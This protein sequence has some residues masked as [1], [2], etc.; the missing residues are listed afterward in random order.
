MAE[1]HEIIINVKDFSTSPG[2]R[3]VIQGE[4]SGELFYHTVLNPQ[5]VTAIE[6][7]KSIIVNLDGV[8][9]YMSSFLDEAFGNL[10]FDFGKEE[11][12][13]RLSF[14][15]EE[16]PEWK[17][18]IIKETYLDW[19]NRR[20]KSVP[21]KITVEHKDWKRMECDKLVAVNYKVSQ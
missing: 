6:A 15:S 9:G 14:I 18:M 5:F 21:P 11:V 1:S 16:E 8:D 13:K 19:E 10:I 7:G 3:Y 4:A 12:L 2:P 17:D 20:K